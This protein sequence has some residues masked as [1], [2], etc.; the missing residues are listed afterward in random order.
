MWFNQS[1]PTGKSLICLLIMGL[2]SALAGVQGLEVTADDVSVSKSLTKV[3][4][5]MQ[6]SSLNKNYAALYSPANSYLLEYEQIEQ[7]W[8]GGSCSVGGSTNPAPEEGLKTFCLSTASASYT[9]RERKSSYQGGY[10]F[11]GASATSDRIIFFML[12]AHPSW[13]GWALG[14]RQVAVDVNANY[15]M[16]ATKSGDY[17]PAAAATVG[18]WVK[19]AGFSPWSSGISV[20]LTADGEWAVY[21][22][23]GNVGYMHDEE[24][25][26]GTLTARVTL[27]IGV[28]YHIQIMA[29]AGA[30]VSM[31]YD[32]EK[33][34]NEYA[35][36]TCWIDPLIELDPEFPYPE[37]LTVLVNSNVYQR[38]PEE[39]NLTVRVTQGGSDTGHPSL[40]GGPVA[41][42]AELAKDP[43]NA[44]SVYFWQVGGKATDTDGM[45]VD[46]S[47]VFDPA[48][49]EPGIYRVGVIAIH[50][51]LGRVGKEFSLPI[52]PIPEP[53]L[54]C[55][56]L[57]ILA[58]AV[59]R[60][61]PWNSRSQTV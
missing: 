47:Y 53:P 24:T 35:Q 39:T 44:S 6:G 17:D 50:P 22:E 58:I 16:Y 4:A 40:D 57:L 13:I 37:G 31:A 55:I 12:S 48:T 54:V 41:L 26:K 34:V 1:S 42:T 33:E 9:I 23:E 19:K 5:S 36:A 30:L 43:L 38:D 45:P 46:R 49:L 25:G 28:E 8:V 52:G 11:Q 51:S 60:M 32:S 21:D 2:C 15:F 20:R 56:V 7:K 27:E 14:V 61:K 59:P 10:A 29:Q 3:Q 18:L